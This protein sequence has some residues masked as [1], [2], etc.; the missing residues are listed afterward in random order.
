M[1]ATIIP[2]M[3]DDDNNKISITS[4][5]SSAKYSINGSD[6]NDNDEK[7][8]DVLS[9]AWENQMKLI[10]QIQHQPQPSQK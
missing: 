8:V 6:N 3:D 4:K 9:D 7:N 10:S 1:P 2:K 5:N